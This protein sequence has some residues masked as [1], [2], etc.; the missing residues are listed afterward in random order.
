MSKQASLA[1]WAI[2]GA[3]IGAV[4]YAI[5]PMPSGGSILAS[6][7]TGLIGGAIVGAIAAVI[8]NALVK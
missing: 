4:F 3:V 6:I 1:R 8:R 7:A 5:N 2:V